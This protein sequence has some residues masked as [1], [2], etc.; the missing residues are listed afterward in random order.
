MALHED[1]I[2][3]QTPLQSAHQPPICIPLKTSLLCQAQIE[4]ERRRGVLEVSMMSAY[5][6]KLDQIEFNFSPLYKKY[7]PFLFYLKWSLCRAVERPSSM[8]GILTHHIHL[9]S[10]PPLS[11]LPLPSSVSQ[12]LSIPSRPSDPSQQHR[13][14][15]PREV[16]NKLSQYPLILSLF[17]PLSVCPALRDALCPAELLFGDLSSLPLFLP[18]VWHGSDRCTSIFASPALIHTVILPWL[19]G[20]TTNTWPCLRLYALAQL[21]WA[22]R[23]Q[24]V[25]EG[26]SPLSGATLPLSTQGLQELNEYK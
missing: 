26:W 1:V 23:S 3:S 8:S 20:C 2:R 9:P 4:T 12:G 21:S 16:P 17:Q 14:D 25:S 15:R 19:P 7:S 18:A 5:C 13:P 11:L 24:S 22:P 10:Q 6:Q